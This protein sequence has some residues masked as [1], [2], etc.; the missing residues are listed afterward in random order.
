MY[1][2]KLNLTIGF[3][4]C[5]R[6]TRD[7]LIYNPQRI[8][9][10]EKPYDWLG[11]GFY[12]WENN[13]ERAAQWAVEKFKRGIIKEPSVVGAVISLGH[14]CDFLSSKHTALLKPYYVSME[15]DYAKLGGDMPQNRNLPDDDNGDLLLRDLDCA[16][17]E[18][19]HS[20]ILNNHKS[21]IN[22]NGFTDVKLF[23]SVRGVFMEGAPVF[24]G[25]GIHEKSHIQ[26]C[27]RNLNSIKGFFIPREETNFYDWNKQKYSLPSD[28]L[29]SMTA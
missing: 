5:D 26:I 29:S 1:D 9:I 28:R 21:D 3:H 6:A 17:I 7:Q 19:M 25:A 11:H 16:V 8:K 23:D 10:S 24:E 22:L 13:Y 14:C 4:G 18:Y 2:S 12:L 20:E 27:V 15:A